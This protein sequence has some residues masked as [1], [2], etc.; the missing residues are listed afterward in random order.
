MSKEHWLALMS[1]PGIGGVTAR[2]L[3]ERFGSI[4]AVFSAAAEDV[5][6]VPRVSLEMAM[7]LPSALDQAQQALESLAD[8]DITVL[9]WDDDEYPANLRSVNDAPP[10]LFVRGD[11]LAGDSDAVA[12][13]G[14]RDP[15]PEAA[16][17]AQRLASGLAERGLTVASGLALGIDTVAHRGALQADDG[18]T[19]AVLGCG[20]AHIFPRENAEL[21]EEIVG[22]GAVLSELRPPTP[23]SGPSL[24]ARDRIVSGLSRAVIIVEAAERS[25]SM[26]T[27]QRAR[28]QGRL[29]IAVPGSP[30]T[31]LLLSQGAQRLDPATV[32]FDEL[33]ERIRAHPLPDDAPQQ[34]GLL[35]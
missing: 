8:A 5:A 6:A 27:A 34:L 12:I 11:L 7:Q 28:S 25:G 30:G 3:I 16:A 21:A 33:A 4:P 24:M 9:T 29:L 13:V 31:R 22:R 26:D 19:I 32:D 20:L 17:S 14:T 23:A 2:K 15:S 18:R 1:V 10:L 35:G